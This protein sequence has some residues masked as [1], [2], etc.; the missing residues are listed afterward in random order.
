VNLIGGIT[1]LLLGIILLISWVEELI[2]FLKGIIPIFFILGG[3]IS[4]YLSAEENKDIRR[5][6]LE[7]NRKY[8][9]P[10]KDYNRELA[11]LKIEITNIKTNH[12]KS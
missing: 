4:T 7:S 1:A 10:S 5:A 9:P 12:S 2:W 6:E 8:C 11:K 3:A